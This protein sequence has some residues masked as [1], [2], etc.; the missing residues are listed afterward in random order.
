MNRYSEFVTKDAVSIETDVD[1]T[2]PDV[3]ILPS[4][5]RDGGEGFDTFTAAL[6]DAGYRVL[7]PQPRATGRSTGPMTGVTNV[8]GSYS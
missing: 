6:A 2:G 4:Y 7:R 3:V 1:G 8:M 5:G